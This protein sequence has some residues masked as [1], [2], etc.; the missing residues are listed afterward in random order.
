[1]EL[2]GIQDVLPSLGS[3]NPYNVVYAA[4]EAL[5]SLRAYSTIPSRES[6]S[7]RARMESRSRQMELHDLSPFQVRSAR[8]KGK[9]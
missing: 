9:V 3:A 7:R 2:A 8:R 1:M 4:M 6:L 5:K